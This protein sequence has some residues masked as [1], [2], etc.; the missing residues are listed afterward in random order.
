[1]DGNERHVIQ[2]FQ[3]HTFWKFKILNPDLRN[4]VQTIDV[5]LVACYEIDVSIK[6][7]D[8]SL[9]SEF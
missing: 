3:F 8:F 7:Y 1:M 9:V 5:Y 6:S 2:N 4:R